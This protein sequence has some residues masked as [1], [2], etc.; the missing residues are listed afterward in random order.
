MAVKDYYQILGVNPDVTQATLKKAYRKIALKYHP[1]RNKD[2]PHAEEKFKEAAKAYAVLSDE[3]KR[4]IYDQYGHEGLEGQGYQTDSINL[5]NIFKQFGNIFGQNSFGEFFGHHAYQ[6]KGTNLRIQLK[7][8]LQQVAKPL[9]KTIKLKRYANCSTC[10]GNGSKNGTAL[11]VCR[12]CNGSGKEKKMSNSMFIHM[13]STQPCSHCQGEGKIIQISCNDCQGQ[14][15]KKIEDLITINLPAGIA[16][17]MEFSMTGKGN[18]P[19]RGGIP[20]DLIISIEQTED[21]SLKRNG[22]DIHYKC[23]ISFVDAALGA[24]V[25]VPTLYGEV[26]VKI[27][28]GTQSGRVM[29]LKNKGLPALDR[30]N[31]IGI[32]FIH[33][34]V[35]T[36]KKLTKEE[37]KEIENLRKLKGLQPDEKHKESSFFQKLKN[38]F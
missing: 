28:S 16:H 35:W 3:K 32:Q 34:Y 1:D 36:P 11:Q 15:R 37:A 20:G 12:S 5:E 10:G 19:I 22:I 27:P 8:S 31:E 33:V 13:F 26:L 9:E 2:N 29:Q 25:A 18:A 7:V 30:S 14:G 6:K 17:G 38:L 23:Y 21:A 4:R 24:K